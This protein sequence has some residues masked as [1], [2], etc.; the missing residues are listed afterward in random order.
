MLID[1][2]I[3]CNGI[4][5][6]I[7]RIPKNEFNR[8]H[9]IG[10]VAPSQRETDIVKVERMLGKEYSLAYS[11]YGTD[12]L[13]EYSLREV[14][15]KNK[16]RVIIDESDGFIGYYP[17]E[18]IIMYYGGHSSDQAFFVDTGEDAY[19]PEYSAFS[20]NGRFR[21]TG[22]HSGQDNVEYKIERYNLAQK[23]FERLCDLYN[24]ME[25]SAPYEVYT[26]R[27]DYIFNQFWIDNTLY[28]R[29]GWQEEDD[30]DDWTSR[31]R[32]VAIT[33]AE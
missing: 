24:I 12:S 25:Y 13:K 8:L 10:Y 27:T 3:S 4:S 17:G 1:T 31:F 30:E 18:R 20:S 23:R 26:G 15:R 2:A 7:Q 32:Y 14:R 11:V 22:L 16:F 33:I 19:N 9:K 21:I 5:Y 6:R 28:F 29:L